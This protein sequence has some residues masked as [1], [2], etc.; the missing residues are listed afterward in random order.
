MRSLGF[1]RDDSRRD[2]IDP[3]CE[4]AL[5]LGGINLGIRAG[6]YDDVGTLSTDD[7]ADRG[8]VGEVKRD[9]IGS[10]NFAERLQSFA[11]L[12]TNLAGRASQQDPNLRSPYNEAIDPDLSARAEDRWRLGSRVEVSDRSNR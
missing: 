1:L 12:P 2:A 10:D 11:Q 5:G 9:P 4:V 8:G 7:A 6:V 3:H